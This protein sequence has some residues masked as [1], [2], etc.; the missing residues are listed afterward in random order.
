MEDFIKSSPVDVV[1]AKFE[2]TLYMYKKME[3][4]VSQRRG[5]LLSKIPELEKSLNAVVY[6]SERNTFET[7]FE[8]NETLMAYGKVK[9][10]QSVC[11]WLGVISFIISDK[12][13]GWSDGGV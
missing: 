6:L 5:A 2:E 1:M 10:A 3:L 7:Y 12:N 13:Q 9:D 11:I 8:L 4:G